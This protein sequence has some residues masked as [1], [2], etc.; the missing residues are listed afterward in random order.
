MLQLR[1]YPATTAP[2][3]PSLLD[4]LGEMV[5]VAG[6][7][8]CQWRGHWK[9]T[10][11]E[12]AAADVH[13]LVDP[14]WAERMDGA[15]DCLGFKPA[16]PSEAQIPGSATWFGYDAGRDTMVRVHV[17]VRLVI[18][19]PSTTVYRL[20]IERA[21]LETAVPGRLF[22]VPA[23]E[24]EFIMFVLRLVQ[25]YGLRDLFGPQPPE[26]LVEARPEFNYLLAQVDRQ[27]LVA[28]LEE[29]LPTVDVPFFDACARSLRPGASRW[30]RLWL[31]WSLHRRLG[32]PLCRPPLPVLLRRI[33]RGLRMLPRARRVRLA[34]GGNVIALVGSEGTGK[35]TCVA[36]LDRWLAR[37]FDV[38]AAHLDHPP[39]S[40]TTR[41]VSG[42]LALRR[43]LRRAWDGGAVE[44]GVLEL[45]RLASAARDRYRLFTK[46]RRFAAAGGIALCE[47]YPVE[48]T[49]L[50]VGPEI[51]RL[52]GHGR[53]TRVAR[54]LLRAEQ[55][56]YR[57][58]TLPDV[59][60]ALIVEPETAVRRT[61]NEPADSVR[62]HSR[63]MLEADWSGTGAHL[64]DAERPLAHVLADV[65]S[66]V[67]SDV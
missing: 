67:W 23:A 12:T 17:L 37:H 57:H 50:V 28:R 38:M 56:Y 14:A 31:R 35:S 10:G 49:R 64:V 66:L 2:P 34:H 5:G 47:S 58:I 60:I 46:V 11:P 54:R 40:L 7:V 3:A 25:A 27:E 21:V 32:P 9:R 43:S 16:G 33:A 63:I 48:Q 53:D 4:R 44:G 6:V 24:L 30:Q 51:A 18:G 52:L 20:P 22:P 1:D 19:G 61:R 36:E 41:A 8:C 39:R 65:K 62:V 15:L 55:G 29:L 45:V 13:L 59:I 26:W 42:L